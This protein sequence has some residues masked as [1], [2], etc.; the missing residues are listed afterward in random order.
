M[1]RGGDLVTV[2]EI[3]TQWPLQPGSEPAP[4]PNRPGLWPFGFVFYRAIDGKQ[5]QLVSYILGLGLKLERLAIERALD[6]GSADVHP[7]F[8]RQWLGHQ[9]LTRPT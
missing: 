6:A 4:A 2:R 5:A 1:L 8:Y 9:R 3:L 7:A